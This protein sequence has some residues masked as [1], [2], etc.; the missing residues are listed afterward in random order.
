MIAQAPDA[1]RNKHKTWR[2]VCCSDIENVLTVHFVLH[3]CPICCKVLGMC[4]HGYTQFEPPTPEREI[5]VWSSSCSLDT[6]VDLA[7]ALDPT[8]DALSACAVAEALS[9]ANPPHPLQQHMFEA[10]ERQRSYTYTHNEGSPTTAV[11]RGFQWLMQW[12]HA[13]TKGGS[14]KGPVAAPAPKA[15]QG[16]HITCLEVHHQSSVDTIWA[17]Y[18]TQ[19]TLTG[20]DGLRW[21]VHGNESTSFIKNA[22]SMARVTIYDSSASIPSMP[23]LEGLLESHPA[24]VVVRTAEAN[25]DESVLSVQEWVRTMQSFGY[26]CLLRMGAAGSMV[27]TGCLSAALEE[28]AKVGAVVCVYRSREDLISK[29]I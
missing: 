22:S 15:A 27:A 19:R 20:S 4:S 1:L 7:T 23:Q 12:W 8:N 24:L 29:W 9:N 6:I 16:V 10:C 13:V 2:R 5:D 25:T 18:D 21:N 14:T 17:A 28:A 3:S 26:T 11:S